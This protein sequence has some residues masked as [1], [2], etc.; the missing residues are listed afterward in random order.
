MGNISRKKS[1]NKPTPSTHDRAAVEL[2]RSKIWLQA[3]R[4]IFNVI[5]SRAEALFHMRLRRSLGRKTLPVNACTTHVDWI[6]PE[7]HD[8]IKHSQRQHPHYFKRWKGVMAW[9]A[10]QILFEF[11]KQTK[12]FPHISFS[13]SVLFMK[14]IKVS[15]SFTNLD[16]YTYLVVALVINIYG[17]QTA[18]ILLYHNKNGHISNTYMGWTLI[19]WMMGG[20]IEI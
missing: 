3:R 2:R 10:R 14:D 9:K 16:F 8:Q 5:I 20:K 1:P 12:F 15:Q 11:P 17:L 19:S 6:L 7:T 18:Y 4:N 13:V